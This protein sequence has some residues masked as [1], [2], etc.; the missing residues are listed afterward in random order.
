MTTTTTQRFSVSNSAGAGPF[1]VW[2]KHERKVV[3]RHR[4]F[5]QAQ[6][7]AMKRNRA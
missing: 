7:A 5:K 3:S 4:T 2:D 6:T 1:Q